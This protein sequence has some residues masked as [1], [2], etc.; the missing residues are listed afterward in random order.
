MQVS[1]MELDGAGTPAT[2][3]TKILKCETDLPIPIPIEELA[4]Q[5]DIVEIKEMTTGGFEGGLVTDPERSEGFIL[6]NKDAKKGR[7]RFTIGHELG[8]FL[9]THHKPPPDGFHCTRADMRKWTDREKSL[10]IRMEVEANEF[11]S[12]MLMP[13]PM[14]QKSLGGLGDPNIQQVYDLARQYAVSKEAA[15]RAYA[16]YHEQA[17]AMIAVKDGV[18]N[19][20]YRSL[21]RF[22]RMCVQNGSLVPRQSAYFQQRPQGASPS[23]VFEAR[24]EFWLDSEFGKRLPDLF[25]QVAMQKEGYAL[26]MLW[27][28]PPQEDEDHDPDENRTSKQRLQERQARWRGR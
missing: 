6:V 24:A 23:N 12:L 18:I 8:H 7:R 13:P 5:L 1:R 25:E 28:E 14:W 11:S 9:L 16:Q 22:P 3:V 21:S 19:R 2:L 26:I 27:A 10:A 4:R 20:V 15:A 17:V